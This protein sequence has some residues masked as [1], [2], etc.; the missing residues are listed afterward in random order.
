MYDLKD[1]DYVFP[2]RIQ[3]KQSKNKTKY[4]NTKMT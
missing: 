2:K 1:N 4:K 3:T